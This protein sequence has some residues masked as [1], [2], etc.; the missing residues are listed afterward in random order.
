MVSIT[1]TEVLFIEIISKPIKKNKLD[2]EDL[3]LREK[4]EDVSLWE[5]KLWNIKCQ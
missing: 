4:E 1:V 2:I 3:N 5:L